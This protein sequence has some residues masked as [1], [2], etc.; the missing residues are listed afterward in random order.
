MFRIEGEVDMHYSQDEKL[1]IRQPR[2]KA[3]REE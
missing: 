2:N 1:M 3:T